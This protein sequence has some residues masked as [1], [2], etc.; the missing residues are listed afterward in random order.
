MRGASLRRA[1]QSVTSDG[2]HRVTIFVLASVLA[3]D[4][5]DRTTLGALAP[6]LKAE[7]H[8]GN[9]EIGL[10]ASAFAIVGALAIVPIGI[11]TDR[12]RR[13]T[14]LLVCVGIWCVAM[15][16]AAAA[17]S[18]AV[19]FAARIT[20]GV[21][22]AAGGPPVTSMIGDLFPAD[23]RGRVLGWVKSGELVGAG[24]GFLVAGLVVWAFSWRG[25]FVTLALL[26]VVVAVAVA[27]LPEPRRGGENDR[28]GDERGADAPTKLEELVAEDDAEAPPDLVLEGDQS[29][30]SIRPAM[31]YVFRVRTV[32]M[33]VAAS[34]LGD[35]FF[36][37]LQVF[38][39]L[40][41]VEQF[42]ISASEASIL[43]PLVGVGGFVGVVA[44]G[45]FGD[46]LIEHGVLNGRLNIGAWS[47]LAAAIVLVPVF[48]VT[49]LAVA[50]PFL[51]VAGALLTAPIAPLEAAR[52]DVVHPQLRGRAEGARMVAR[53]AAQAVAPLVFGVL[54]STF[55][56]NEA[57]GLQVAF[58][59]LL[60][61]LAASSLLLF[62][63]TRHYPGEVAAVEQSHIEAPT[64]V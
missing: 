48:V 59:V 64:D 39:V 50:L 54:S 3:L 29:E 20:L 13:V 43:I 23:V 44:G 28:P 12:A 55:G 11:L 33:I 30:L 17:M 63:A 19:L 56:G 61:L 6:A 47:Y 24:L 52:L 14:I 22:S 41:L 8:I 15:G 1:D 35:V 7:F 51:V 32:V 38:G 58:L 26:G 36:T 4:G 60:P 62:V 10:L 49:S 2:S 37:A 42:G 18:F 27:R 5:A 46:V 31:E 57:E 16:V 25:V 9:T 34:A 21:L 45:K 40:Y 53:V